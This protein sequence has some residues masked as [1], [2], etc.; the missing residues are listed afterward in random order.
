MA[1][2]PSRDKESLMAHRVLPGMSTRIKIARKEKKGSILSLLRLKFWVHCI[3]MN[4]AASP[5]EKQVTMADP[6]SEAENSQGDSNSQ[7]MQVKDEPEDN[8][9]EQ[10]S[11][12]NSRTSSPLP[13]VHFGITSPSQS[14]V[15]PS[16]YQIENNENNECNNHQN[17]LIGSPFQGSKVEKKMNTVQNIVEGLRRKSE[18]QLAKSKC[19]EQGP[20]SFK[21]KSALESVLKRHEPAFPPHGQSNIFP[22]SQ[23][24]QARVTCGRKNVSKQFKQIIARPKSPTGKSHGLLK[25]LTHFTY[26][27]MESPID[28]NEAVEIF[29][30]QNHELVCAIGS[31]PLMSSKSNKVFASLDFGFYWC[32][33]CPYTSSNKT[34]LIQHVLEHRFSCKYCPYES[35]C[36]SDTMRH[37]HKM[38]SDFG[39]SANRFVYCTLL[40][41]FMRIK[42]RIQMKTDKDSDEDVGDP[43]ANDIEALSNDYT[44]RKRKHAEDNLSDIK[45]VRSSLESPSATPTWSDSESSSKEKGKSRKSQNPKRH[46]PSSHIEHFDLFDVEVEEKKCQQRGNVS[47][48]KTLTLAKSSLPNSE[49]QTLPPGTMQVLPTMTDGSLQTFTS[50]EAKPQTSTP[51]QAPKANFSYRG[52]KNVTATGSASNL[53]W[54]CGYCTFQSNGQSEIKEHSN[55]QH[56]GKPHR[57]VA[58]IKNMT[59]DTYIPH[60]TP[61]A[62]VKRSSYRPALSIPQ[63]NGAR[64]SMEYENIIP[65]KNKEELPDLLNAKITSTKL[66]RENTIYRCYHCSYTAKRHSSLKTHIYH[67]HRGKGLVAVE[68][69]SETGQQLFF[70]AR[71]DCTFKTDNPNMYLNHVDQCTPWNKPELA[72]VEVEP[73]IRECLDQTIAFAETAREKL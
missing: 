62:N 56:P 71:D 39:E 63:T 10:T 29:N 53:Y 31:K 66:K 54:S 30:V 51:S 1:S 69:E 27:M 2:T 14:N 42:A 28:D 59:P 34:A 11:S 22:I 38:H 25:D 21:S 48:D 46:A 12:A 23:N 41:D 64:N 40:S 70:C 36:R 60:G 50:E 7:D 15:S 20:N 16:A 45:S 17:P 35:F 49:S 9:Y 72:D 73:H 57:Y 24:L 33:F 68:D 26:S 32:N 55:K 67:K 6:S 61:S 8:G 44:S 13:P 47:S 5:F 37:M 65:Q 3:G 58:L 43:D 4:D 52:R 19:D 18:T